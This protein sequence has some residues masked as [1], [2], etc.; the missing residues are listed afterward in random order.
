MFPISPPVSAQYFSV[1]TEYTKVYYFVI[2]GF[3]ISVSKQRERERVCVCVCVY[4]Y[5]YIYIYC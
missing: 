4:I 2:F 1:S 5:M 3:N